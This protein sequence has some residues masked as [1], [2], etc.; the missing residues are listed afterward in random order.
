MLLPATLLVPRFINNNPKTQL[1]PT[2]K[3]SEGDTPVALESLHP[4]TLRSF[5]KV[6]GQMQCDSGKV[7]KHLQGPA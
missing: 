1:H 6:R 5:Q 2:T 4:I 3:S 7:L